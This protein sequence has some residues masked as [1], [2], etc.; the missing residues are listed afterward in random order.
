MLGGTIPQLA[1]DAAVA[2]DAAHEGDRQPPALIPVARASRGQGSVAGTL[3]VGDRRAHVAASPESVQAEGTVTLQPSTIG[4][5]Q[6]TR[7]PGRR[8]PRFHLRDPD[9]RHHRPRSQPAGQRHAGAE[10]HRPVQPENQR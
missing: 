2:R 5:L 1:F 9:T 8:V 7:P 10:R 6:I 3:D 4:G